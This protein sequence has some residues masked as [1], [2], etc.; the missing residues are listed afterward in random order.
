MTHP[1][2]FIYVIDDEPSIRR[3]LERLLGVAGYSVHSF[4]CAEDFLRLEKLSRPAC[5]I[6]DLHMPGLDGIQLQTELL[7]REREIPIIFITGFGTVESSVQAMKQGAVDFLRK[8]YQRDELL[9]AV[10][11]ALELDRRDRKEDR[12]K[13]RIQRLMD[14]LTPAEKDILPWLIS[15]KLN[16]QIARELGV[17]EQTIKVHRHRAM[18]KLGVSSIAELVYLANSISLEPIQK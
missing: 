12:Q 3:S 1:A 5:L 11:R 4:A 13:A 6:T 15:G 9:S 7:A 14:T 16:K 8:P 18:Q 17:T 10:E 2:S